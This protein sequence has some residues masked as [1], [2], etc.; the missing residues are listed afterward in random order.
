MKCTEQ[1][2][3]IDSQ[4]L[5]VTSAHLAHNERKYMPSHGHLVF[6]GNHRTNSNIPYNSGIAALCHDLH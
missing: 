1:R 6:S 3:F 2:Q 5:V 4:R